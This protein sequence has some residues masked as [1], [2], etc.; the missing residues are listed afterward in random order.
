L[1]KNRRTWKFPIDRPVWKRRW[2]GGSG[3]AAHKIWGPIQAP[4]WGRYST[5]DGDVA[6]N[7]KNFAKGRGWGRLENNF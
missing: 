4:T 5:R 1:K 7:K 6:K 3:S 2:E